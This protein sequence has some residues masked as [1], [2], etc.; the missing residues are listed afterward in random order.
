MSSMPPE[1]R[2]YPAPAIPLAPVLSGQ[3][4]QRASQSQPPSILDCRHTLAVTSGRAAIAL[5]LEQIGITTGDEV[6][7]P[8][9]HCES[10]VAPVHWRNAK[11][12]FYRVKADTTIDLDDLAGRI[13]AATKVVLVSHYFGFLQP[14][15]QLRALCDQHRLLLIEDC[16][17]SF[18][19]HV[20]QQ[21]DYAIAS[22]MKF[23]PCYDGGILA[24][25]QHTLDK[26]KLRAPAAGF[27][28]KSLF[29]I[30]ERAISYQR[31]GLTGKA[32]RALLAVKSTVWQGIKKLRGTT[33]QGASAPSSADGGYGLD[34]HWIHVASSRPSAFIIG[35]SDNQRIV[36]KRRQ[37]YQYL[38]Q[39]LGQLSGGYP[40]HPELDGSTVPLVYPFYVHTPQPA[41]DRL[42]R[43]GVP[44]WRFGEF[45][46]PQITPAYCP[47]STHLSRHIFQFPCHQELTAAELDWMI[48]TIKSIIT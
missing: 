26:C 20:G 3:S 41:F 18:F 32:L 31:L 24:S 4:L 42:K 8:A 19:G 37:H 16:A 2:T 29:N 39:Q 25:H 15:S 34:E 10:M 11:P 44:I 35:H 30:L 38:N 14:L 48:H 7:V 5:A 36:T 45:L 33:A 40:L 1:Y 21:G 47:N 9:Y 46:D 43:A 13:T 27:Q 22:S 23:F 12:V 17:H 28:L 6:L